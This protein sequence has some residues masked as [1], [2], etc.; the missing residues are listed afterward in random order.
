MKSLTAIAISGGIDS[1]MA[2][3]LLKKKGYNLIGIHFL[4][5]Y[6]IDGSQQRQPT[7]L[8][9]SNATPN[10]SND[11][12]VSDKMSHIADQ[13][14]IQIKVI[15]CAETFKSIV[16][17]YFTRSYQAGLTPN[18]CMLCNPSIK[19][20][21]ILASARKLG[22][23]GLATGHYARL[24]RDKMGRMHLYK[25]KDPVKDQSYFLAFMSQAKLAEAHF[26]LGEYAKSEVKALARQYGLS[27]V[28]RKESQDICF[29]KEN[30]YAD[31][32]KMQ[33]GFTPQPGLIEDVNGNI[34]GE[35][36]GLHHFTIGQR[37]GIN[38]PATAP[39]YVVSIDTKNNRLKVGF[40]KDL[41]ISRC[42]VTAVNWINQAPDSPIE[43]DVR[44][45]YRQ[46]A[47]PCT[48][49]PIGEDR[50][51]VR[52]VT[53][54]TAVTPGQAAVFYRNKEVLGG[55]WIDREI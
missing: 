50:V 43:V 39:Y 44:V 45:R 6:E 7:G 13:L 24:I 55:G 48:V 23:C 41:M 15:D 47:V 37:R 35:H 9:I 1:L 26:P 18:P 16:V 53:P 17:D 27:P 38:C 42:H 51:S 5:G 29:I 22:A 54:Q 10:L 21:Q 30:R 20:G 3:F 34:I 32:L 46:K 36:K 12:A 4:T 8:S 28:V 31:F 33:P 49:S 11:D 25:G 52:F 19:F 2:A 14:G 40:K